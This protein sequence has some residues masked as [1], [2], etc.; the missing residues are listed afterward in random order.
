MVTLLLLGLLPVVLFLAA[1]I[2]MDSYKLVSRRAVAASIAAGVVS[3]GVAFAIQDHGL[4][5]GPKS[6]IDCQDAL[7]P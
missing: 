7:L 1:L 3:A 4:T 2:L 5:A 6:G